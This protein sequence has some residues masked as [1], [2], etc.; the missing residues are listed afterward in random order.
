MM[1]FIKITITLII[2]FFVSFAVSE[3]WQAHRHSL[4]DHLHLSPPKDPIDGHWLANLR[5]LPDLDDIDEIDDTV[6]EVMKLETESRCNA[7]NPQL[8][9]LFFEH[10][11]IYQKMANAQNIYLSKKTIHQ[12]AKVMAMTLKESYGDTTNITDFKGHSYVTYGGISNLNRWKTILSLSKETRIE[13]NFQ[14][15]FGLTQLSA[16]RLFVAFKLAEDQKYNTSYL[17]GLDGAGTPHKIPLNAAIAVRR[18]IWF[19]QDFAQGRVIQ[20]DNRVHFKQLNDPEKVAQQQ[21]GLEAAIRYCGTQYMFEE[22]DHDFDKLK[23]AMNSV[24]YCKLGNAR[25]G[26]GMTEYDD[27]CFAQLVT[28]CPALNIDIA[29]ITPEKYF[30]T[31]N[32]PAVCEATFNRLLVE[33]PKDSNAQKHWY[34][35]RYTQ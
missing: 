24:A 22:G 3:G 8:R 2:I 28:I 5:G 7:I 20:S 1:N 14:T 25:S 31:R 17:E 21:A 23:E 34:N 4:A 12:W 29:T 30:A 9:M 11:A 19:Y 35:F 6:R 32:E 27:K 33:K 15:N 10:F 16:D 26:Y 13:F 18:L